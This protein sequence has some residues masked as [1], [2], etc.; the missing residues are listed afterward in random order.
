MPE[1]YRSKAQDTQYTEILHMKHAKRLFMLAC[2]LNGN[3]IYFSSIPLHPKGKDLCD[4][5]FQYLSIIIYIFTFCLMGF[6]ANRTGFAKFAEAP[7]KGHSPCR[8]TRCF[9]MIV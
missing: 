5:Y 4:Y 1:I 9:E 3:I 7:S 2:Q 8:K 6:Q